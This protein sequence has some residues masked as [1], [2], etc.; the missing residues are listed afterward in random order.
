MA[1]Y[2]LAV[3][4]SKDYLTFDTKNA[5]YPVTITYYELILPTLIFCDG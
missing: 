2:S 5:S 3:L 4:K 1:I